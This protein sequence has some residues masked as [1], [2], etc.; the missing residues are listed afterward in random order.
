MKSKM[1]RYQSRNIY[2]VNCKTLFTRSYFL[3]A[4][5]Y[6][7]TN[8]SKETIIDIYPVALMSNTCK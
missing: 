6:N 7:I 4:R 2:C 1:K 8:I 3:S 5:I